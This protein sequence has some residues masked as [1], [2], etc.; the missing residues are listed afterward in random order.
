[1]APF[2]VT[3]PPD[4]T[5]DPTGL[6]AA[7]NYFSN[8]ANGS[9]PPAMPAVDPNNPRSA[10]NLQGIQLQGLTPADLESERITRSLQDG[11]P[12]YALSRQYDEILN[13]RQASNDADARFGDQMASRALRRA[14]AQRVGMGDAEDTTYLA[15]GHQSVLDDQSRRAAA[16]QSAKDTEAQTLA[17]IKADADK[18][19]A[20][21]SLIASNNALDAKTK[22]AVLDV[23]GKVAGTPFAGN[24]PGMSTITGALTDATSPLRAAAAQVSGGPVVGQ[25]GNGAQLSA[26]QEAMVQQALQATGGK[27]TR[28][29]VIDTLSRAG[30]K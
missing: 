9:M 28:E 3:I 5:D 27:Y 13:E 11:D 25:V 6:R 1:M 17:Q 4:D 2:P 23:W 8:P 10:V 15:P 22:Q 26:A 24:A 20:G 18:Y 12:D 29:Q 19:K 16:A 7:A 30:W 21:V 14:V